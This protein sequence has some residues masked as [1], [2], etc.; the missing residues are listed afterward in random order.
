[1]LGRVP[2][3]PDSRAGSTEVAFCTEANAR[4]GAEAADKPKPQETTLPSAFMAVKVL[5]LLEIWV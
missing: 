5:E 1:M 2:V 4:G 3:I